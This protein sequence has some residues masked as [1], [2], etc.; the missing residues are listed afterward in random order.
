MIISK[1]MAKRVQPDRVMP[2]FLFIS[3]AVNGH[4]E[5]PEKS[6]NQPFVTGSGPYDRQ[7]TQGKDKV[8]RQNGAD[9]M[10]D[11]EYVAIG[12]ARVARQRS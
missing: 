1:A 12:I 3:H 4:A 2:A 6:A 10:S 9:G 8:R 7:I 11:I 5:I